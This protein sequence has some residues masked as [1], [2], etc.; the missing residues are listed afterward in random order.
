LALSADALAPCFFARHLD[1]F[2]VTRNFNTIYRDL[3]PSISFTVTLGFAATYRDWQK[4]RH[5]D[6]DGT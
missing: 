4:T 6:A 3:V 1:Y 5:R 2:V